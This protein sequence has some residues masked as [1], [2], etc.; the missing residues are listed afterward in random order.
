MPSYN[1]I[2]NGN[3]NCKNSCSIPQLPFKANRIPNIDPS[4][5][6]KD[7]Q[8]T[9]LDIIDEAIIY[10]RANVLLKN[11]PMKGDADKLLV[12]ITV[13]IQKCLE[14]ISN[15][16]DVNKA[17]SNLKNLIDDAEYNP[18]NKSHFFNSLVT[19]NNSE[20]TELQNY[21]KSVRKEVVNR[22]QYLLFDALWGTLDLK[23]WLMFA[24]RRFMGYEMPSKK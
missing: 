16:T 18:N 12:Y 7:V 23:F 3:E 15:D 11:F 20:I 2:F 14:V 8:E 4:Q 6:K 21:L 13:F 5:L 19:I 24:K 22:M 1:F 9:D 10:F 17:K